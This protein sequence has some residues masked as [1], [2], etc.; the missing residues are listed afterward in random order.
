MFA[1]LLVLYGLAL[2]ALFPSS[3][4]PE[5][6]IVLWSLYYGVRPS[7]SLAVQDAETGKVDEESRDIVVSRGNYGRF[8]VNCTVWRRELGLGRCDELLDQ[9]TNIRVGIAILARFQRRFKPRWR[10]GCTCG[11]QHHWVAHYNSGILA[12]PDSERYARKVVRYQ[13]RIARRSGPLA[14]GYL[15]PRPS[16]L[17]RSIADLASRMRDL[18]GAA[19]C[20][21]LRP[22][23]VPLPR[24]EQVALAPFLFR[25]SIGLSA[26]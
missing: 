21:L 16:T 4:N 26:L 11:G 3:H 6:K 25:S 19:V 12:N 2:P 9:D 15:I 17:A 14:I 5:A 13:R 18:P 7:L 1:M 8:Q 10:R 20:R 24:S 22:D 23:Q